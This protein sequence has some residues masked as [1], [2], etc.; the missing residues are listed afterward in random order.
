MGELL[1]LIG[2]SIGVVLYAMLLLMVVRA[3]RGASG[4]ARVDGLLVATSLLGLVWN[5]CSLPGSAL[6]NA[7]SE[8][9]FAFVTAIGCGALGFLPAVV[10][11][12]VLRGER[13]SSQSS[14]K[15]AITIAAYTVSAGAAALQFAS[16]WQGAPVPSAAA[17]R[18]LTYAFVALAA[19]V[20][21]M[22]MG[23]RRA[24]R[25]LW[26][27]A[28]AVFAVSALH[29]SQLHR[30]A[31]AWPVELAGHHASL[32]LA[33]AILYQD[34]PFALADL[35][36]K[37]TLA[38]L[39]TVT[40]AT[41]ALTIFGLRSGAFA[42]FLQG[43]PR[44]VGTL[45]TLWV[46]TALAYPYVRRFT[47]WFVD[48]VV[49][50]RPDYRALRAEIG[51]K[52]QTETEVDTVLTQV[53][54]LL[55]PALNSP[56]VEWREQHHGTDLTIS[57]TVF[58]GADAIEVAAPFVD[59]AR[60]PAAIVLI[61]TSESPRYLLVVSP[62]T[63]GRR[64]LSDDTANLETIA[65]LV[66]RRIDAIRIA[67]ERDERERREQE[68][69]ALATEAELRALRAQINPHFLFNALTTIGYL[70]QTSP[71]SAFDTLMRL[72]SLLRAVLRSES[73]M[74]SLE[75]EIEIVEAYLQIERAR[76]ES[77]LRF[78]IDVPAPLHTLRVPP[79][80]LQPLVENAVKHGIAPKRLGGD[81]LVQA[82]L[83][84][85]DSSF[86]L[87]MVRDTGPGA[88]TDALERG[89]TEGVGLS[90]VERRLSGH[91]G[92]SAALHVTASETGGTTVTMRI[93][94]DAALA[95]DTLAK[96]VAP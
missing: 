77:R 81:V 67:H 20:A 35:F 82:R 4:R 29:L 72:T 17:M 52:V 38:L 87:L 96:D 14:G 58:S 69:N 33:F 26:V 84:P 36:L 48:S 6:L 64:L 23:Q 73:E 27:S 15:R 79:L 10:V 86:V 22:T 74:T 53:C 65:L 92:A 71:P 80:I 85:I 42:S 39:G 41:I 24:R 60:L 7:G 56:S 83:D 3:R 75:R 94:L 76:F 62:L 18:L 45:V 9:D 2:L 21:A 90:N 19:P 88:T 8:T 61:Q 30:G 40:I 63:G 46:V 66:A 11:H 28:L 5:L 95:V 13:D 50:H 44:Q 37:R 51:Q 16:A 43:D 55:G 49:L 70:I 34:Y 91:Y 57:S 25:A 12:S 68:M 47:I 89:R 78:T 54:R 59:R 32:P 93:P 31:Y 1:N